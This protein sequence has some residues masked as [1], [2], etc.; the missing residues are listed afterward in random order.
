MEK[1]REEIWESI[2]ME[3]KRTLVLAD[4]KHMMLEESC[5]TIKVWEDDGKRC[6]VF[7]F[8]GWE[9]REECK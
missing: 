1:M 8:A 2:E 5:H 6:K 4:I 9:E 3:T 7:R